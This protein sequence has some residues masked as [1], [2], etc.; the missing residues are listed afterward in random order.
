[1]ER[2]RP[3]FTGMLKRARLSI[4]QAGYNT[5]LDILDAGV[6]S[7]L[8]PFAQATETEQAQRA[9]AL[10]ARGRVVVAEEHNLTTEILAQAA[11]DALALPRSHHH[12]L[13]GGADKSADILMEDLK[14]RG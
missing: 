3:D 7:V 10:A 13:L 5:I 9:K 11:D 4:S 2:A 8:V 14:A 12:V 6:A 1:M